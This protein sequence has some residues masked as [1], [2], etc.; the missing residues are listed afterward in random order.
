MDYPIFKRKIYAKLIEWKE[1]SDAAKKLSA[2]V[3]S[4]P[5][6]HQ[7]NLDSRSLYGS[8]QIQLTFR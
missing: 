4:E 7:A 2:F 5:I 1:K 6:L 8:A 3:I